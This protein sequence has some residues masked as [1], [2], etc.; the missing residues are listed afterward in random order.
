MTSLCTPTVFQD[1]TSKHAKKTCIQGTGGLVVIVLV[2]E[3]TG[4]G[5]AS[6]SHQK[7]GHLDYTPWQDPFLSCVNGAHIELMPFDLTTGINYL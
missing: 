4:R 3:L 5:V 2:W 7:T 6:A 1:N